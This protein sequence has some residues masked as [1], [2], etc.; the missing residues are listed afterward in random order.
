M[1]TFETAV[2]LAESGCYKAALSALEIA[3]PAPAQRLAS[4]VLRAELIDRTRPRAQVRSAVE[5]LLSSKLEPNERSR[6]E[7][8]LGRMDKENG[9]TKSAVERFQRA[10]TIAAQVDKSNPKLRAWCLVTLILAIAESSGPDATAP[11]MADL[12]STLTKCGSARLWAA[13]HMCGA[14]LDARRGLLRNAK[15]HTRSAYGILARE[16][17]LWIETHL[18]IV[19]FGVAMKSCDFKVALS[20]ARY[21]VELSERSGAVAV[22]RNCHG[23]LGYVLCALGQYEDALSSFE[24][25]MSILPSLGP[26]SAAVLETAA[27]VKLAQ[28]L[29]DQCEEL[30]GR[31]SESIRHANDRFSYGQREAALTRAKLLARQGS[32]LSAVAQC[33][34]ALALADKVKDDWLQTHT[35]FAK[36]EFIARLGRGYEALTL[37]EESFGNLLEEPIDLFGQYERIL[38]TALINEQRDRHASLHFDRAKRVYLGTS[39]QPEL[40]ELARQAK[41]RDD[42]RSIKAGLD[43]APEGCSFLH[44]AACILAHSS[45]PELLASEV[46]HLLTASNAAHHSSAVVHSDGGQPAVIATFESADPLHGSRTFERKL[47]IRT[48]ASAKFEVTFVPKTDIESIATI[49]SIRLLVAAAQELDRAR[50]EREQTLTL[51]PVDDDPPAEDGFILLGRMAELMTVAKRVATV[52]ITV[53]ITGESGTGKEILARAVHKY[54]DRAAKPFVPF[55]C[56]AVPRDLV[57]SHL[58]GHRRGAFTGADR[59]QLGLIRAAREGTLFLDEIGELGLD[60]QPKLLRFLESGEIAPLGEPS[61]MTVDVRIVAA[62]NSNLEDAVRGGRF[63]EDLFYRLN[64]V[65]LTIPPLR[66]RR[67][68]IPGFVNHFVARAAEEF[69]KGQV[70]VAEETMERLLLYRWPGNVR[71]LQNEMRR[72][73]ALAEADS[74]LLPHAIS[75]DILEALPIF[76]HPSSGDEIAVD[77]HDKLMPAIARVEEEM[78]KA[79]LRRHN[80]KVEA[81][82]KALGISRKGLYLKRQRLGL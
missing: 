69:K 13:L 60:L 11:L 76:R 47:T 29:L 67:D 52:H 10:V 51:W 20:H 7:I 66:E 37:I 55:N 5:R 44:D 71:Q 18:H 78:I 56:A 24:R 80:G 53:L 21:A 82:A 28:G 72:M 68:E 75:D 14:S 30:L 65:R 49:N 2:E 41:I 74:T 77:L 19:D 9:D 22:Q 59:D 34:V 40:A 70:R 63:R 25:S 46:A 48:T 16:P 36:A 32:L 62:T 23:N 31:M 39:D 79:A 1:S 58:F 81:V 45:R 35:S 12:R 33:D 73:V 54:S 57:E 42:S 3:R 64:V 26:N 15:R 38:G 27:R 6:C 43:E 17:H 4:E 50:A 8:V 61:S